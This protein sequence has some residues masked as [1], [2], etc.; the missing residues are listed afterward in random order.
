MDEITK[1]RDALSLEAIRLRRDKAMHEKA[2]EYFQHMCKEDFKK[3]LSGISNVTEAFLR[4]IDSIYASRDTFHIS[5]EKQNDH[6]EQIRTNCTTLSRE[7]QD[8]FQRYLDNVGDRVSGI[9]SENTRLK[10]ENW[11]LTGDYRWCSQNR[12]GT[13]EQHSQELIKLQRKH[14]EA[15]E[16]LLMDK[17][18]LYGEI[19]VLTKNVNYKTKEVDHLNNQIRQLN[20]SCMPKV[21]LW[22][23]SKGFPSAD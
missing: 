20:M 5:C 4:K 18:T 7:V 22:E 11:R 1:E 8:R 16:R 9:Q 12:T 6:F 10:A 23:V 19:D 13:I 3:S 14:D 15:K 17:V 21:R 2:L